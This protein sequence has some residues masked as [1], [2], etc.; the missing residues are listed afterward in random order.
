MKN[1][2]RPLFAAILWVALA[3]AA[4][5]QDTIYNVPAQ[6]AHQLFAGPAARALKPTFAATIA[7][8]PNLGTVHQLSG[9][10]TTSA[11]STVSTTNVGTFGQLMIVICSADSTGTVTYTFSTNFLP[12]A[13]VA[14]TASKAITVVFVSDAVAWHEVCRSASAQ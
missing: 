2:L 5:A 7:I 14:A 11:T 13:T 12:T 10:N 4:Y 8:N 3:L 1:F 6:G 9:V